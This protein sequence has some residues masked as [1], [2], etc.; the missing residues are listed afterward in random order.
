MDI[1][2]FKKKIFEI[3]NK[4]EFEKLALE[5]F[6]YQINNNKFYQKY[7]DLLN[8]NINRVKV[9]EDI[10]FLPIEFFKTEKI[11]CK[12]IHH[13]HVFYSSGTSSEI[14][15]KHYI[16]DIK[17]YEKNSAYC[18]EKFWG[19]IDDYIFFCLTPN[20]IEAP[21]SSLVHM[22]DFFIKSSKKSASGFYL[23]NYEKLKE[24]IQKAQCNK[25][26]FILIGLSF[27]ILD[28]AENNKFDLGG[29]YLIET[30]GMKNKKKEMV[31]ENLYEI[32]KEKFNLNSIQSEYGMTELLSQS[33][34]YKNGEF[35]SPPWKKI[36]IREITNPLKINN[37]T[38]GG[39]NIIDLSNINSC[40]FIA[41]SDYGKISNNNF[42]VL[43]RLQNSSM[44]GC[45]TM[46]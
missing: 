35:E 10:P 26:P 29:G 32:L 16:D 21:N 46:I 38:T 36:L 12:N 37:T 28:L 24:E 44:R 18:F 6:N 1:S 19:N 45:N 8:F 11:L 33:Y 22:C 23:N 41:T 31:R 2:N 34:S 39:I 13:S 14:K 17:F 4:Q 40:A 30:G 42:K 9:I 27:A 43:G 7:C 25:K 20:K 15:S 5:L 3:S